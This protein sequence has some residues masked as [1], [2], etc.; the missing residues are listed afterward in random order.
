MDLEDGSFSVVLDKGT[1]DALMT[2]DSPEVVE[3]AHS[4]FKEVS[5]VL[6]LGGRY[7]C[8]SLAQEHIIKASLTFFQEL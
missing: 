4:L 7:I 6:K 5:R 2:D 8:I 3:K 1:L